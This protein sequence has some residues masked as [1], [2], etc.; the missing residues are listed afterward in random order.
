[1][2]AFPAAATGTVHV[3]SAASTDP[4]LLTVK[5]ARVLER[6]DAV[7][8]D[9]VGLTDIARLAG[10][11]VVHQV[12]PWDDVPGL[13]AALAREGLSV[14]RLVSAVTDGH[15]ASDIASEVDALHAD[16]IVVAC[17][18]MP[19]GGCPSGPV[20]TLR[21]PRSLIELAFPPLFAAA[22]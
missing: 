11:A 7:V 18:A 2:T 10:N 21:R 3:I 12:V 22:F 1:M 20:A 15:L 14:V 8:F 9:D 19:D 17:T 5:V 4:D 16:G 6:A 13:L